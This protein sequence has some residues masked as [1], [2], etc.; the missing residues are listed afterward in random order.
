[1]KGGVLLI[2]LALVGCGDDDG[3]PDAGALACA[4]LFGTPNEQT[5]LGS[6]RCGPG[7]SCGE[8]TFTPP[9]H[10][11]SFLR[12][13]IEDWRLETPYAPLTE[14]PYA[15]AAPPDASVATVCAVL[16]GANA[17]ARPRTYT[18][19]TFASMDAAHAAGARPTHYGRCGVCST[20]ENLAV[21]VREN[22][23]TA[24]VRACAF[25]KQPDGGGDPNLAC[26]RGLGFDLPCAQIWAYNT[27][28]T[29]SRC[30][31]V[32]LAS[33]TD[34]YNLP[35]GTLNQC[36]ACDERESGPVF[37]AVA[38]RTRRNSGLPNA[39]CRPCSEVQPLVH[40]Y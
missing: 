32:C 35:D 14:D 27:A 3:E 7:C 37:K 22:D 31:D 40:A 26:L 6:D 15:A 24:P 17:S 2:A 16:P 21:Y 10:D 19:A 33:F 18:L 4:R 23:L 11:A 38:G 13:L 9:S 39:I 8:A 34:P 25:A 12:S 1:M 36:L 29:R 20:L 28:H 30:L 5:G